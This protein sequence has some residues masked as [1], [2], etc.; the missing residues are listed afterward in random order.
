M[1]AGATWAITQNGFEISGRLCRQ[2]A[3]PEQARATILL[4]EIFSF[5]LRSDQLESD[6][7][8]FIILKNRRKK[9]T[10]R[11]LDNGLLIALFM[12]KTTG[13]MQQHLRFNVRNIN[14]FMEIVSSYLNSRPLT[15]R[16]MSKEG[17]PA[18]MEREETKERRKGV[19]SMEK[20]CTKEKAH[21][22]EC[23]QA[24]K[25]KREYCKGMGGQG[26]C[27][28]EE[29]TSSWFFVLQFAA[30]QRLPSG[31]QLLLSG[32]RPRAFL[33]PKARPKNRLSLVDFSLAER[34]G[35]VVGPVHLTFSGG[36]HGALCHLHTDCACRC[37]PF[38]GGTHTACRLHAQTW[39]APPAYRLHA[40]CPPFA[41]SGHGVF[42]LH[43]TCMPAACHWAPR[44]VD[45]AGSL[46]S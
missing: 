19:Y 27:L 25:G 26:K 11:P 22:K 18:D 3:M 2:F 33:L 12:Q 8:D 39:C 13:P 41:G 14:T 30:R 5:M 1:I 36:G 34:G 7:S 43:A 4:N 29:N 40:D 24:R 17:G 21:A 6:L 32:A 35:A 42:Y 10:G 44:A 38:A 16:S 28:C 20:V 45:A 46:F 31:H 23:A 15:V 9:A 37:T